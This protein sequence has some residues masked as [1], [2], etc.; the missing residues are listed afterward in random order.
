M[1]SQNE[2]ILLH[3]RSPIHPKIELF[4]VSRSYARKGRLI[5]YDVIFTQKAVGQVLCH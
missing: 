2:K 4:R 1:P 5:D 3:L